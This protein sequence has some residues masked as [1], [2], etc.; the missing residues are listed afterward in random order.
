MLSEMADT[1][2]YVQ[3]AIPKFDGHYDHWAKLMENF[4]RSKEYWNLV[5]HDIDIVRDKATASEAELKRMEEQQLKDLKIKN[6]LYQAIDREILDTI[7]NDD[8][9]KDI[10]EYMN[11][12]FQGSTRVKRAQLHALRKE[13]ETLQ[14]REGESVKSYFGCTL[15]IAKSMKAVGERMEES[16]IT[17]KILWSMTTK[18]NYVVCS[19][20]ESNNMNTMIIDELQSSL[21]VHKQRMACSVE[22]E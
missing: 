3:P 17:T 13:F 7:L 10:Q 16:V 18:F 4:L 8:T 2:K 5:E 21:L 6:Y 12:K 9:S 15:K 22:E 1:S 20:E 11:Q 19:I 14:I